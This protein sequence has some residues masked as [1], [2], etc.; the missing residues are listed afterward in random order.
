[1]RAGSIPLHKGAAIGATIALLVIILAVADL[2]EEAGLSD[3]IRLLASVPLFLYAPLRHAPAVLQA[4][5]VLVWWAA[6]GAFLAWLIGRV[7]FG[8]PVAGLAIALLV[9]GQVHTE[10]T[11][12][13]SLEGVAEGF[14]AFIQELLR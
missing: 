7:R 12:V 14:G 11:I 6:A 2:P 13:R 3:A 1:M 8:A 9:L 10:A 5:L 4:L